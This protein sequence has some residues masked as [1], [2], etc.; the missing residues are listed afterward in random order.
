[1]HRHAVGGWANGRTRDGDV[2]MGSTGFTRR[3]PTVG[4]G[5]RQGALGI[6]GERRLPLAGGPVRHRMRLA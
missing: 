3:P 2:R 6:G 1:M 4:A 5:E